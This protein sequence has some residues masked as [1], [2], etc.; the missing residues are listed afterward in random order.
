MQVGQEDLKGSGALDRSTWI[1]SLKERSGVTDD[2]RTT[3]RKKAANAET[4][5]NKGPT[6]D[7]RCV[8][9]IGHFSHVRS[10]KGERSSLET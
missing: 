8:F 2:V 3:S 9:R 7:N 1:A 10:C 6:F 5:D 4:S